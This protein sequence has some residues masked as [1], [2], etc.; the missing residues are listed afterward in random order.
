M[1]KKSVKIS[2]Y[3]PMTGTKNIITD[4]IGDNKTI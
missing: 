3:G 4:D 2:E 1:P